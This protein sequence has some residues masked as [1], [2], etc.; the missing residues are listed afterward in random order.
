MKGY[1]DALS[2]R[3]DCALLVRSLGVA[4]S[5]S[6]DLCASTCCRLARIIP[7]YPQLHL[8]TTNYF[9]NGES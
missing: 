1:G 5:V 9:L 7:Y 4:M 6:T 8:T 2:A 3:G